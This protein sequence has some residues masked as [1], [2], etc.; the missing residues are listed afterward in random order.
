MSEE[1]DGALYQPGIDGNTGKMMR[2]VSILSDAYRSSQ[3]TIHAQAEE[4]ARLKAVILSGWGPNPEHVQRAEA[5]EKDLSRAR[6]A[7]RVF[8]RYGT[9][10]GSCVQVTGKPCSCGFD[11]AATKAGALAQPAPE[12]P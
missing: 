9:H 2:R 10:K 11:D 6:E 5:L 4:I 1:I 8:K 3:S 7:V 12:K